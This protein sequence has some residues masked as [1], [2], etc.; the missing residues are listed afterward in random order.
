M[1]QSA[2]GKLSMLLLR[3]R[4]FPT[5][6]PLRG[7]A[8]WWPPASR[9]PRAPARTPRVARGAKSLSLRLVARTCNLVLHGGALPKRLGLALICRLLVHSHGL[10]V[11][12]DSP[13]GYSSSYHCTYRY[14]CR[15]NVWEPSLS[16][17]TG[18]PVLC[19][20]LCLCLRLYQYPYQYLHLC[21]YLDIDTSSYTI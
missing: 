21:L 4:G 20:R 18:A 8:C 10:L 19:L 3:S 1:L 2:V 14:D 7:P 5:H 17:R 9:S 12:S 11:C 15:G 16:T 13:Y 6:T